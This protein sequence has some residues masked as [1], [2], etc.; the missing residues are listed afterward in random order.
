MNIGDR[1]IVFSQI[2]LIPKGEK[3]S[4]T[5]LFGTAPVLLTLSVEPAS[6]E[7]KSG[8]IAWEFSA[9]KKTWNLSF[10]GPVQPLPTS[11][12]AISDFALMDEKPVGFVAMFY[13][14]EHLCSMHLQLLKGA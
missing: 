7:H 11:T 3:V 12:T 13:G 9:E 8:T 6:D 5:I 1:E 2:F 10:Y 14:S 4:G